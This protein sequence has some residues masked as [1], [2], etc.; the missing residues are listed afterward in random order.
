MGKLNNHMIDMMASALL[1]EISK[2]TSQ[3]EE[4][5]LTAKFLDNFGKAVAKHGYEPLPSLNDPSIPATSQKNEKLTMLNDYMVDLMAVGLISDIQ[6]T[7][8][9]EGKFVVIVGFINNFAK[10]VVVHGYES[11]HDFGWKI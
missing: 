10:E 5:A 9:E 2:V 8:T 6:N 7:E 1:E 4:H 11:T 3:H